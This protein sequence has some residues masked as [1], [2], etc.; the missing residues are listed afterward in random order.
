MNQNTDKKKKKQ[1]LAQREQI[2]AYKLLFPSFLI[3]T[4]IAAYPLSNV[5]YASFTN[6]KFASSRKVEF[7][8]V[9]NYKK[10]LS[11]TIKQLESKDQKT[12]E[13]LP[14]KPIRYKEFKKFSIGNNHYV[15]GA[16]NPDFLDSIGNTV[17]FAI[18][19][20]VLELIIGLIIALAVNSNFRGKGP[21]RAV[22]LV[23]WAVITVVSARIWEWMFKAN[24]TG[25][26]NTIASMSGLGDG[27]A[28]FLT[29]T[30]LQLPA[31]IAVDVWK[32]A[33]FMALL[34][35]AGLQTIPSS[36]YEAAKVDGAGKI[37]Q[38]FSIT[39]PLLKPTIA[40][41]LIFRTLD[42]LRAFDV[43]QV[44]LADRRYSMAS[45]NYTQLI[46]FKNMGMASAIGMIIFI[47][48]FV[49]AIGYIK[50]LGVDSD[51]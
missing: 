35:L 33:P 14:R 38:F 23:P 3:L 50:F 34:I 41:A 42:A 44:L 1:S 17:T 6:R 30:S 36:L 16:A 4:I 31:I 49:F 48:I 2:L 29:N 7:V 40:I 10:L 37:R 32:T 11:V 28:S 45:Y 22:M 19:S 21:M 43:F 25:L 26:F 13:V 51:D 46:K 24:R 27:Q 9:Q 8:G 18:W 15:I 20:V 12:R 47:I 39:L 5:F